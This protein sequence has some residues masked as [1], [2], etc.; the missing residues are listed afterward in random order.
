MQALTAAGALIVEDPEEPPYQYDDERIILLTDYFNRTD[1]VLIKGLTANP[2]SWTGEVNNVLVNGFGTTTTSNSKIP[3]CSL[4]QIDVDPGKTYRLRFIGGTALSFVSLKFEGH[5]SLQVIEADGQYTKPYETSYLQFGSGQR[6]SVLLKTKTKLQLAQDRKNGRK[7]AYAMQFKTL[8]RPT[9]LT[10][11]GALNYVRYTTPLTSPPAKAPL[12]LPNTTLGFLDDLAPYTDNDMPSAHEVTR[13][14]TLDVISLNRSL[15]SHNLHATPQYIW[16]IDQH[17][18]WTEQ[19]PT[20]PYLVALYENKT[21]V[22]PNYTYALEHGGFDKRVRAF[23]GKLGEVLD[24]VIQVRG[25]NVTSAPD[26]HPFHIHG[27]H[28]WNLGSG[29]GSYPGKHANEKRLRKA[30]ITPVL[31]DSTMLFRPW[32][33][34]PRHAP[35]G[36]RAWRLKVSEPGAWLL[37]CHTLAHMIMV[38]GILLL[39]NAWLIQMQGMQS[40]WVFGDEADILKV[41]KP[42]VEGYLSYGGGAYGNTTHVPCAVHHYD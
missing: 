30:G 18:P 20:T 36:W 27:R 33:N 38:S 40:V 37:H 4:N 14:V 17:T 9:T 21:N 12:V 32:L 39:N 41:P 3:R 19:Y 23:P 42:M 2:F 13:T 25:L 26:V 16:T 1:Q 8:E 6:Y 24:I 5:D 10:S 35:A 34:A 31:R 28:V 29:N 7:T 11:Y 22:L 15:T